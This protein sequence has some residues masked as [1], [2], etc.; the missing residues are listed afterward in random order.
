MKW[1]TGDVVLYARAAATAQVTSQRSLLKSQ[2]VLWNIF[3]STKF[4]IL[5]IYFRKLSYTFGKR[6][7][8]INFC[9]I[10]STDFQKKLQKRTSKYDLSQNSNTRIQGKHFKGYHSFGYLGSTF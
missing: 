5:K 10:S 3:N 9:T 6:K 7:P 8:E 2:H 1:S 4:S